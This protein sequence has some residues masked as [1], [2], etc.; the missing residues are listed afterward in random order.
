MDE[1]NVTRDLDSLRLAV[2]VYAF[3]FGAKLI[4]YAMS[5]V[6]ALLA[7]TLHTLSDIFI[8]GFLWIAV[9]YS[10]RQADRQHP[11][12]YGR[13]QNVAALVAATLFISFTSL[14]LFR[15]AIPRL[16]HANAGVYDN[17][18]LAIVVVV[19]SM[20]AAAV[21]LLKLRAQRP[22]GSAARAQL[23]E[24][25]NDELGLV[26]ALVASVAVAGG[27]PIVDPIASIAVATLIAW[28]AIALLRENTSILLGRSPGPEFLQRIESAALSVPGV[29]GVRDLRAEYVGPDTVHAG[30]IV[31]LAPEVTVREADRIATEVHRS[32]HDQAH[33]GYCFIQV[34][35]QADAAPRAA[36]AAQ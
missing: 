18:W 33:A 29:L 16:M 10:R 4:A 24:L 8:S 15:E 13:A 12:G 5:G 27:Y 36:R 7:E 11:F 19:V 20:V 17:L 25:I 28:N 2:V 34:A 14:E 26:A 23:L 30:M 21:P 31:V 1:R 22:L 6:L 32:V 35:P 9:A 3:I